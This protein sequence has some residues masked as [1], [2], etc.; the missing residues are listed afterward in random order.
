MQ[1]N[2]TQ[3]IPQPDKNRAKAPN[4]MNNQSPLVP[5]GSL[6]EQKN[7]GRTRVKVA[8]FFVLTIHGLGLLALLMQ[9]CRRDG[10]TAQS[11]QQ[12]NTVAQQ[13]FEATNADTNVVATTPAVPPTPP[14]APE[15]AV[16]AAGAT[17]YTIIKG[18][19][20]SGIAS[21]F[22]LT[23][24][25]L[26]DA[27]PGVEPAKL[28]IGKKIHIPP[29][30]PAATPGAIAAAPPETPNG[31]KIYTVKSG[32]NLSNIAH[33]YGTTVR[34]IRTANNLQTDSIK[35]GQKLKIPAKAATTATPV[36]TASNAATTPG[37]HP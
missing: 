34:A 22:H 36:T 9:G 15:P 4:T 31:E 2:Q 12:T 11:E 24:R 13:P 26:T 25:A 23:V 8:V 21:H 29:P 19:T 18:D 7:K 17:E 20:F 35:V 5:Q 30:A 3:S 27:N 28:Q 16:P 32:D 6:L 1:T 37:T 33:Q 14:V 10:S